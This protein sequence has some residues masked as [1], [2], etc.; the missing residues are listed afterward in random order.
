LNPQPPGCSTEGVAP[1]HTAP[2]VPV[3]ATSAGKAPPEI[4]LVS[5]ILK[6][7]L[8]IRI[9]FNRDPDPAFWSIRTLI[10]SFDDRKFK[11]ITAEKSKFFS[12]LLIRLNKGCPNHRS[13]HLQPS[14]DNIQ[15]FKL[16][17]FHLWVIFAL[18]DPGPDPVDQNEC[19]S[20]SAPLV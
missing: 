12:N 13:L 19:G 5:A 17:V 4:T 1:L 16:E 8:W 10:R 6:A 20:G 18:M 9:G 3:C 14:K 11:K 7:V 2:P 15:H